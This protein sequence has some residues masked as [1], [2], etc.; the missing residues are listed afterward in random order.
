[1]TEPWNNFSDKLKVLLGNWA[2]Y[3]TVSSFALYLLGYL[4]LR[5]HLTAMGIGTDLTVLDERYL[6]TG[7]KFLIYL[8]SSV[9]I[10][11]LLTLVLGLP[12]YVLYRLGLG[13]LWHK[14]W[15]WCTIPSRL[16]LA[17]IV[18][19]VVLIQFVMRQCFFLSNLLLAPH[20]PKPAWLGTLLLAQTDSL[21]ALYF[22][23]LVAGTVLTGG[24]CWLAVHGQEHTPWSHFLVRLL[25]F[26]VAV[27]LLMLPVNYGVLIVDKILPKVATLGDQIALR[28]G[29][30]AWLVW[31]GKDGLT[32][33]LW[34]REVSKDAQK[35]LITLPRTE[36]K[37]VEILAYDRI[38][39]MLF[40]SKTSAN[41]AAPGSNRRRP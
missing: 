6:F 2:T 17:G 30:Q 41:T 28:E 9:P 15:I 24:L 23:G 16:G 12:V 4:A 22:A 27:Q 26:L 1:M 20:L 10:I 33:L 19:S 14:L 18:L 21:M 11:V 34:D 5:F 25:T 36:V 31:E 7:A 35:R 38:L 13:E 40:G 3:S 39:H 37:K 29:Q 32:Y 8:V